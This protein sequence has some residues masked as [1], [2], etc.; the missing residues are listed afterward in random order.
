MGGC[1]D[2]DAGFPASRR[3]ALHASGMTL[4]PPRRGEGEGKARASE[5]ALMRGFPVGGGLR[6]HVDRHAE[7][8]GR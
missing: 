5:D 6:V 2:M 8:H 3:P 4:D 7:L 1:H